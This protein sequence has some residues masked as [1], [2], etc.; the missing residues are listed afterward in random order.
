MT[1]AELVRRWERIAARPVALDDDDWLN[2]LDVRQ[3]LHEHDPAELVPYRERVRLAD[4][5]FRAATQRVDACLWGAANAERHG[6]TP[7]RN[8]WYWRA[9]AA[10]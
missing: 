6:W 5:R 3:L 9:P 7:R 4:Q 1:A 2:D 10:D 8:W